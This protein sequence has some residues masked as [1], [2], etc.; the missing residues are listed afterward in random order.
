MKT[1]LSLLAG[2]IALVASSLVFADGGVVARVEGTATVE[3]GTGSPRVL[4]QGDPVLE[5]DTIATGPSSSVIVRFE[6]G[7]VVALSSRARL[8]VSTYQYNPTAKTGNIL[9]SLVDG[10][11]RAL[12]G[13]IG[14]ASPE[15]V[16]YKART[17]TIG[18]RGTTVAGEIDGDDLKFGVEDGI[19]DVTQG[20]QKATLTALQALIAR[21]SQPSPF[22]LMPL[23]QIN[24]SANFQSIRAFPLAQFQTQGPF[25]PRTDNTSS[26][27]T[28]TPNASGPTGAGGGGSASVR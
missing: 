22:R 5:G 18:I 23:S 3:T 14:K 17:A 6:D 13:L 7:Q 2:A 28:N 20:D 1:V 9:L 24:F 27:T 19:A 12:T 4:R 25:V 11:M 26:T 16:S 15:A 10:G 21:L 8:T